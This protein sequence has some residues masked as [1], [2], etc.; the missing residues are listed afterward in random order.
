M[1]FD[2]FANSSKTAS[3]FPESDILSDVVFN[4]TSACSSPRRGENINPPRECIQFLFPRKVL[5]SPLWH[6]IRM[7]CARS[8]EGNVFVENL[9][10]TNAI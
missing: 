2:P 10:W 4:K 6:I 3:K 1:R 5:I 9:E 8:H 7:G